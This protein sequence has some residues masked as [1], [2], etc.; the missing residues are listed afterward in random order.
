M[1]ENQKTR[2]SQ[3]FRDLRSSEGFM[4]FAAT[5]ASVASGDFAELG[6]LTESV[7]IG[8]LAAPV[9]PPHKDSSNQ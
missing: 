3:R 1:P 4:D 2:K 5:G 8:D 7:G 6:A 9:A